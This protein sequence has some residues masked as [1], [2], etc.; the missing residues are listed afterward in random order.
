MA[1]LLTGG[2]G[3]TSSC[4]ATLLHDAKIQFLITSR[5]GQVA[6]PEG[7]S[8]VAVKFDWTD[9]S[10]YENPFLHLF[11]G[12][13]KIT[14]IYLVA[15][16]VPEPFKPMIEFVDLALKRHGVKRFVLLAVGSDRSDGPGDGLQTGKVWQRLLDLGVEYCVLRPTWFMDNMTLETHGARHFLSIK[17]QR[18]IYTATGSAR[19]PFISAI[20]IGRVAFHAL[21][22]ETPHNT[23][24]WIH[25]PELLTY[26]E[27]I[28]AK[29]S[30]AIGEKVEHVKL[31]EKERAKALQQFGTPESYAKFLASIEAAFGS[32]RVKEVIFDDVQRATGQP[33]ESFDSFAERNKEF[34]L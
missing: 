33:P 11:H 25:G 6:A 7:K 14:S 8:A 22:D 1:I 20:D 28:A 17:K 30:N 12:G 19:I 4:L 23:S 29:I 2:T 9:R 31:D 3:K 27:V 13:E 18:K 26:D 32:G 5:R 24:Y 34:W 16:D 10:T 21:V 15:P